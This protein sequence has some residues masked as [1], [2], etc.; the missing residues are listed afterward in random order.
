MTGLELLLEVLR[1][2]NFLGYIA[3]VAMLIS[4]RARKRRTKIYASNAMIFGAIIGTLY[5]I[6]Q[7]FR[8]DP[9]PVGTVDLVVINVSTNIFLWSLVGGWLEVRRRRVAMRQA[10]P[11]PT[12]VAG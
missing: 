9:L 6:Y 7:V 1:F 8:P 12:Q 2:M 5:F 11:S 3:I 10:I 4:D